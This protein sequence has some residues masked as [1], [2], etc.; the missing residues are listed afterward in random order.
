MNWLLKAYRQLHKKSKLNNRGSAIVIVIIAMGM[1]GILAS[2]ILWTAY[3]NYMIKL[4]DKQ[5]KDNFYS[6]EYVVEQIMAGM[7]NE[8][9]YAAVRGYKQV[10]ANWSDDVYEVNRQVTFN[11]AFRTAIAKEF[12]SDAAAYDATDNVIVNKEYT[13][14]RDKLLKYTEIDTSGSKWVINFKDTDGTLVEDVVVDQDFWNGK[15]WDDYT[16]GGSSANMECKLVINES[17]IIIKNIGVK[18]TNQREYVSVVTTDIVI[19]APQLTFS[20]NG[21]TSDFYDFTLIADEGICVGDKTHSAGIVNVEGSIF[22]GGLKLDDKYT[23]PTSKE[24]TRVKTKGGINIAMGSELNIKNAKYIISESDINLNDTGAAF[25]VFKPTDTISKVYTNNLYMNGGFADLNGKVYAADDLTLEGSGSSIKIEGEY[26]GYG[27]KVNNDPDHSSAII[28]NGTKSKVDMRKVSRL[29]LAGRAYITGVTDNKFVADPKAPAADP[30]GDAPVDNTIRNIDTDDSDLVVMGESIAVKGGQIAYMVP[31]EA[32]GIVNKN[33]H[34][35]GIGLNPL[36]AETITRM[37]EYKTRFGEDFVDV[38]VDKPIYA[39]GGKTLR[40]YVSLDA[41][42][43]PEI[44]VLNIQYPSANSDDKT[45][46]YYYLVMTPENAEKYFKDYY[47]NVNNKKSIDQYFKTY[48][49]YG[50]MLG[51]YND[52]TTTEYSIL[53]N[54]LITSALSESGVNLLSNIKTTPPAPADPLDPSGGATPLPEDEI[55]IIK[56]QSETKDAEISL[57]DVNAVV[58]NIEGKYSNLCST[59]SESMT[60]TDDTVAS[61]LVRTDA[62]E[63]LQLTE[64]DADGNSQTVDIKGLREY[65]KE[66]S[67][68]AIFNNGKQEV[69]FTNS[70]VKVSDLSNNTKLIVAVNKNDGMATGATKLVGPTVTVDRNFSGIIISE[71]QIVIS[72]GVTISRDKQGVYLALT[73]TKQGAVE[74]DAG[75]TLKAIDFF[76]DSQTLINGAEDI[77]TKIDWSSVVYYNNWYKK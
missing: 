49:S 66:N 24:L 65:L 8:A 27:D 15:N 25:R 72:K 7:K 26:Y 52:D 60:S 36:N 30:D 14:S 43:K 4:N 51:D 21:K 75:A 38:D 31:A 29:L 61:Y 47:S 71:G 23:T 54:S 76:T 48:A 62:D 69:Y 56:D 16:T 13:I 70:D 1:I 9:A 17:S 50:I 35:T 40:Q 32:I 73:G 42:D 53:G 41:D 57:D 10:M 59:L 28:I 12:V 39:L 55:E 3:I 19:E 22:A 46:R 5:T 58:G 63:G 77:N 18:L 20:Q 11:N 37:N 45:M 2:T 6:A 74:G 34:K 64:V 44:R 67:G 33:T 68:S